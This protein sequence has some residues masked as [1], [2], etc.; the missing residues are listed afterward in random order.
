MSYVCIRK[1]RPGHSALFG[2]NEHFVGIDCRLRPRIDESE[3]IIHSD[4]LK[5]R[6]QVF[7]GS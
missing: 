3:R 7:Q 6:L 2:K 5:Q 4:G 1:S